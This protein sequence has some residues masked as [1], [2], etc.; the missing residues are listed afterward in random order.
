MQLHPGF[1][2]LLRR[3]LVGY[4]FFACFYNKLYDFILLP[5]IFT[6]SFALNIFVARRRVRANDGTQRKQ[7]LINLGFMFFLFLSVYCFYVVL[8]FVSASTVLARI[9]RIDFNTSNPRS[10]AV[11][12]SVDRICAKV[13]LKSY[14]YDNA[15]PPREGH[16]RRGDRCAQTLCV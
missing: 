13:I 14:P 5:F 2:L 7:R 12:F 9:N 3:S 8:F 6:H 11:G 10:S 1:F 16:S 15:P 4:F